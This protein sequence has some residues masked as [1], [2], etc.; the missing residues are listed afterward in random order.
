MIEPNRIN[1]TDSET[2]LLLDLRSRVNTVYHTDFST[3]DK[4]HRD[5]ASRA[6]Y[7][8]MVL[9]E[10]IDLLRGIITIDSKF[11]ADAQMLEAAGHVSVIANTPAGVVVRLKGVSW[12]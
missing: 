11:L 6:L 9:S 12:L 8:D 4:R 3:W 7:P 10:Y 2:A 1:L 5:D